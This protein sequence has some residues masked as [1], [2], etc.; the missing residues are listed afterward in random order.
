MPKLVVVSVASMGALALVSKEISKKLRYAKL[1]ETR[2]LT[3][4]SEFANEKLSNMKIVKIAHSEDIEIIK[5][6]EKL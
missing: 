2:S 1:I 3:V 4:T 6:F 5:Y